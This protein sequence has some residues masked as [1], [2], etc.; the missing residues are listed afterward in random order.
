MKFKMSVGGALFFV[1]KAM[2]KV[3]SY[4]NYPA[5]NL[6]YLKKQQLLDNLRLRLL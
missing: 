2:M 1:C 4:A 3:T 6:P 5:V